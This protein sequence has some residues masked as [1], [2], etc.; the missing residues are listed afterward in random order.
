[1]ALVHPERIESQR[2]KNAI[3]ELIQN[4][5]SGA[6]YMIRQLAEGIGTIGAAFYPRP[7]VVRLSDFKSNE[8]A[9]RRK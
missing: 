2:D 3:A 7:V 6:D 9:L 4:Y 8:Y 5:H 1:M